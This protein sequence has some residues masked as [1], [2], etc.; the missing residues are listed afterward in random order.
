MAER[1]RVK[2]R[3]KL[4]KLGKCRSK[5]AE[6]IGRAD[7]V[8]ISGYVSYRDWRQN[9]AFAVQLRRMRHH[10]HPD[11][12]PINILQ[13][14]PNAGATRKEISCRGACRIRLASRS[15]TSPSA[16]WVN[17][18][19]RR[20]TAMQKTTSPHSSSPLNVIAGLATS[21]DSVSYTHLDVY[22]RQGIG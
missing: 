3:I 11:H 13:A 16:G 10:A 12:A 15:A 17:F 9:A 2:Q 21:R 18:A 22:K 19:A 20:G 6:R 14:H 1:I 8:Y 5:M 4:E 7:Q